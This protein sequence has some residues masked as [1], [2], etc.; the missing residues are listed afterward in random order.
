MFRL[1]IT[2][3]RSNLVHCSSCSLYYRKRGVKRPLHLCNREIHK[4]KRLSAHALSENSQEIDVERVM[5]TMAKGD[6]DSGEPANE[7]S[8][9]LI[10]SS[11]SPVTSQIEASLV[12]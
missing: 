4:R 10:P 7:E 12:Q 8:S 9:M 3:L 2:D 5:Q 6:D 1:S 11:L